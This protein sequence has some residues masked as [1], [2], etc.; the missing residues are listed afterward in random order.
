M[1]NDSQNVIINI[2]YEKKDISI[3]DSRKIIAAD[4]FFDKTIISN[5]KSIKNVVENDF[6]ETV[7]RKVAEA[8]I[9]ISE[10][11][12][13]RYNEELAKKKV[14]L[15]IEYQKKFSKLLKNIK[16]IFKEEFSLQSPD[17]I[18]SIIIKSMKLMDDDNLQKIY[19]SKNN[20]TNIKKFFSDDSI[21]VLGKKTPIGIGAGLSE[22]QVMVEGEKTVIVSDLDNLLNQYLGS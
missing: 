3:F 14:E 16:S 2:N 12:N 9:E 6:V 17:I 8:K 13:D 11:T 4:E 7:N 5:I 18:E 21:S 1:N 22:F 15:S 20:F 19:I 10:K